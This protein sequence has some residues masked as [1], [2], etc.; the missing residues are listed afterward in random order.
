M[1]STA[2][3]SGVCTNLEVPENGFVRPEG[4]TSWQ[5]SEL[6]V[7]DCRPGYRLEGIGTRFCQDDGTVF[8]A[9]PKCIRKPPNGLFR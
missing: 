3:P 1:T 7:Y 9:V 8:G 6:I 4:Q 2:S 5:A